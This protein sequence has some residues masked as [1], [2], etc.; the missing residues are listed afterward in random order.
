MIHIYK[1]EY[2]ILKDDIWSYNEKCV[3]KLTFTNW[4]YSIIFFLKFLTKLYF[5]IF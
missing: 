3:E 4:E 2:I 1:C 5:I